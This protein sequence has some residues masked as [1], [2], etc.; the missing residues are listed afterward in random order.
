MKLFIPIL[1][2]N[3]TCHTSYM[4]SLF[5]LILACKQNQI[6]AS[7]YP[8]TFESLVSRARN[9]AVA[10][11]MSDVSYTHLLF[12]D[13]DIEFQPEDVFKLLRASKPVVSAGYPQKW[14]HTG[15]MERV[16]SEN[17]VPPSP[18]ELCTVHST[19][20]YPYDQ[21]ISELMT[22]KYCTTGFLLIQKDVISKMMEAYPERQYSNDID[23]Y[24]SADP[25]YFYDL[26]TVEVNQETKKYES[27]DYGFSRLWTKLGGEIHIVT[28]ISLKHYGWYG[29]SGNLYRQL[30]HSMGSHANNVSHV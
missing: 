29:F 22:A 11:F 3:H 14:L 15:K 10:H 25:K 20:L 23:G 28:D 4:M 9:A 21:N 26:F 30:L 24:M 5:Q 6:D 1:C 27:E 17:P 19:H 8:I 18:L 7:F 16:F 2:Y 13:S 12:I